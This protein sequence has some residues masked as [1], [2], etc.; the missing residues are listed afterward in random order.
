MAFT[1]AALVTRKSGW[2]LLFRLLLAGL[3]LVSCYRLIG[4]AART[5]VSR[6]FSATAIIQSRVEAADEAVRLTPSDPEA[7]YTRAL[8]LVNLERLSDA[9][10]ELKEATRLRPHHYYEWLDLGVTLDRLGDQAGAAAA[11]QESVRLAPFY[12][13]PRWQL[14][15]LL[16]RQGQYEEAFAELRLGATSNPSLGDDL[17]ALAWV[18]ADGDAQTIE[19]LIRPRSRRDRLE[20]ARFLALRGKGAEAVR[21]IKAAGQ[22]G[23]EVERSLMREII[24]ALSKSKMFSDAYD[25]WATTHQSAVDTSEKASAQLL[26]GDFLEPI[27]QNNPGF[28]WQVQSSP[29]VLV[30]IDPSGPAPGTRS[31]RVEYSGDNAPGAQPIYQ[32]ILVKSKTRYSVTFMARAENL[33]SGGP[34]VIIAFDAGSNK[35]LGQSKPLS[36][37]TNEWG[38]YQL[39]FTT[40]NDTSAV[41]LALQR[42][43]CSQPTCPVFGKLWMSRFSFMKN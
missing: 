42:L 36:P 32:M 10:V 25:A 22:P 7:H 37:G 1:V 41:T 8:A 23:D 11:L 20:F 21:Q 6:L 28:G 19:A 12:A 9:V 16:Y 26:N 27:P 14:G 17:M 18:A 2:R 33:V 40:E 43:S 30:S 31:V 39:D 13:Q 3:G 5:G 15:N 29:M 24:S 35:I 38:T 4:D 34:P